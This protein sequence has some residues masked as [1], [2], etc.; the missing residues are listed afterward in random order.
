MFVVDWLSASTTPPSP[1]LLVHRVQKHVQLLPGHT[2]CPFRL[3]PH[4]LLV[5]DLGLCPLARDLVEHCIQGVL[6]VD[7]LLHHVSHCC[8]AISLCSHLGP[9]PRRLYCVPQGP[10]MTLVFQRHCGSQVGVVDPMPL[11][12][13]LPRRPVP[14]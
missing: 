1:A 2:R 9:P 13:F 12:T 5:A 6:R 7:F 10:R 3:A 8:V 14:C 4:S 11:Q